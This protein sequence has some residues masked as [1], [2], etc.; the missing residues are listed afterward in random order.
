MIKYKWLVFDADGTL[1]DYDRAEATAL[2]KTFVETGLGFEPTHAEIY[3][4]INHQIWREF[5][6]GRIS[7]ERLRTRRF[8]QLFEQ[9]GVECDAAT[10]SGKYLR[11]LAAAS[12][13]MEGAE[14]IVK[15]L[16]G[17]TG[18]MIMTNGLKEVQRPRFA[19]SAI[20]GYFDDIVI[21][22]EV[23][24]AKPDGRIFDI[25]F[26]RMDHPR[27]QDVL[28]VG[29]SLASDIKGGSDYG[30]DTC[31]FNPQRKPRDVA[32]EIR[33]EIESL[34]HLWDV[35]WSAGPNPRR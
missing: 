19:Q 25:A 7:Q 13:L 16:H 15:R 30:I 10:F 22:E 6:Q 29:D 2:E 8:E 32:V 17:K 33:Y 14:D 24:A 12:Q 20:G 3:R 34:E 23:G 4:R 11:N 28:I 31:W 35:V 9:I 21:S 5:E 18:L 27:K 26:E 1:F